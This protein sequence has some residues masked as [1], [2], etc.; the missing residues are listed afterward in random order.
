MIVLSVVDKTCQAIDIAAEAG[1]VGQQAAEPAEVSGH[2]LH[3]HTDIDHGKQ[4]TNT[5]DM[6]LPRAE[7]GVAGDNTE[8]HQRDIDAYLDSGEGLARNAADSDG[9]TLAGHGHAAAAH[10]QGDAYTEDS[11]AGHLCRYLLPQRLGSEPRSELHV[12]VDQG[13]EDETYDELE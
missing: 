7:E 9:E 2:G 11:A 1:T 6:P 3:D 4:G 8:Q 13:S 10:L 5:D 12:D